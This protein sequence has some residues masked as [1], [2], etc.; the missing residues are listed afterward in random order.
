[1]NRNNSS[2]LA[3]EHQKIRT[4][5]M[6]R[7]LKI[8]KKKR[9]LTKPITFEEIN[10]N[11]TSRPRKKIIVT[12]KRLINLPST[13]ITSNQL[14]SFSTAILPEK[15]VSS[16]LE[17]DNSDP[18]K[19]EHFNFAPEDE[20]IKVTRKQMLNI[21]STYV[22]PNQ[23]PSPIE[24]GISSIA[25]DENNDSKQEYFIFT[26]EGEDIIVTK[27]R[28]LNI[29]SPDVI[30]NKLMEISS[31]PSSL[32]EQY[33]STVEG[34]ENSDF[35]T[36]MFDLSSEDEEI[37]KD[38]Q[39]SQNE[40][41][42]EDDEVVT[43]TGQI[44]HVPDYEPFFP[45]LSETFEAPVIL[46][47]TTVL[48][49]LDFLTK[50]VTESRLRTY[51]F[52]ITRVS[53]TEKIVTSTTEVKPHIKTT[54]ITESL[55]KLTTLTLL[56]F[57]ASPL[58]NQM[59]ITSF[60]G[61]DEQPNDSEDG[62]ENRF[63]EARN[64]LATRVMSN[65][66]EVIVAGDK[67]TL[68]GEPDIKR[69]LPSTI[70]KP[71]TLKAS[72]LS[73]H[74]MMLMPSDVSKHTNVASSNYQNNRF[75]TKTCL[76]TF[77]YLTT[78]SLKGTK[79]VFSHEQVV[80]NIAT[81]ERNTGAISTTP[82]MGITLTQYA[83]LSVGEFYTT[84]TYLNSI[85][86]KD[87]TS[88][89]TSKH[90]VTNTVTAPDHYLFLIQPSKE[91]KPQKD[92]NTYYNTIVVT[93]TIEDGGNV[94]VV[95]TKEKLTQVVITESI[96]PKATSVMTSYIALD[97]KDPASEMSFTTTDVV[98]T[99]YV[100]YTYYN[101]LVENGKTVVHTN[102]SIA[103]DVTTEKLF[104]H[105]K[106]VSGSQHT[107]SNQIKE[108]LQ[109]EHVVI[110]ATKTYQTT[111]TYFTTLLQED[112]SDTPTVV[113]SHSKIV[114]NIATETIHP[115]Q[116]NEN[117]WKMLKN[118]LQT[119]QDKVKETVILNDGQKLEV[120][121]YK[122]T[123]TPT[124]VLP[125]EITK[126]PESPVTNNI[127]LE[128]SN[129]NVITGSTIIFFD[130]DP[131]SSTTPTPNLKIKSTNKN[132]ASINSEEIKKTQIITN[133]SKV[134]KS[135]TQH[136]KATKS[137]VGSRPSKYKADNI[138][139]KQVTKLPKPDAV[140]DGGGA[141]DLLG[142]GSINIE[143]LKALTPVINAMAGLIETNLKSSR[144]NITKETNLRV[145]TVKKNKISMYANDSQNRSPIY[146]PVGDM[147]VS[148]SQNIAS[149]QLQD[150]VDWKG[151]KVN[152]KRP[153]HETPLLNGG[154]PISPGEVITANSDVIV[155]KPGR[156]L[157]R[158][159][160]IP[161]NPNYITQAADLNPPP[162]KKEW[163][164][165][166]NSLKPIPLES[167]N[168]Y[169]TSIIHAV[170]KDEYIGPPPPLSSKSYLKSE[171]HKN[172]P[173]HQNE[174]YLKSEKL[175]KHVHNHIPIN[176]NYPR[177]QADYIFSLNNE[178]KAPPPQNLNSQMASKK[179]FEQFSKKNLPIHS[180]LYGSYGSPT[181][182]YA[183]NLQ[184]SI[185]SEPIVLPEIIERST[186]Q[187]LLVNIQPSQI[188]FVNIPHNRTTALI[189][190]GSTEPHRNGQYF[191][192]PS[193]YSDT[194][195]PAN[196][197]FNTIIHYS[198]DNNE[199]SNQKQV[200]SVIKVGSHPIST[201]PDSF[202]SRIEYIK[203]SK[204]Q[205]L[206]VN[207]NNQNVNV[208]VP[209]IS[210]GMFQSGNDFNAHVINHGNG[211]GSNQV[212]LPPI[213]YEV[214]KTHK[215]DMDK[216]HGDLYS[217]NEGYR[218]QVAAQ[219]GNDNMYFDSNH[220]EPLNHRVYQ[221]SLSI[222]P[223]IHN[224][225]Q[226]TPDE[227]NN[228][229]TA[230][231]HGSYENHHQLSKKPGNNKS[232]YNSL[233]SIRT[234]RPDSRI[235]GVTLA[236]Y[237]T[238]PTYK[239]KQNHKQSATKQTARPI[240][241]GIPFSPGY[242][243]HQGYT[244]IPNSHKYDLS[245]KMNSSNTKKQEPSFSSDLSDS[246][247][248][249]INEDGELI[250][251][252]NSR[253]LRPGEIPKEI[254]KLAT[255]KSSPKKDYAL[256]ATR[257]KFKLPFENEVH[258]FRAPVIADPRPFV[259]PEN[260]QTNQIIKFD[261]KSNGIIF[262]DSLLNQSSIR[263]LLKEEIV[264]KEHDVGQTNGHMPNRYKDSLT[265]A[266]HILQNND[267]PLKKRPI[268]NKFD[269]NRPTVTSLPIDSNI[270]QTEKNIVSHFKPIFTQSEGSLN[271]T[272]VDY[273]FKGKHIPKKDE[274]KR[275]EITSNIPYSVSKLNRGQIID[276]TNVTEASL[277]IMKP[278]KPT[279]II[280]KKPTF[281][282]KPTDSEET[283]RVPVFNMKPI[284][285]LGSIVPKP[286]E[287]IL[288]PPIIVPNEE[289]VG[290]SP[291][292]ITTYR[293]RF[294]SKP[295]VPSKKPSF[296]LQIDTPM[297]KPKPIEQ[298][299]A[300]T[301]T[302]S[303][304]IRTRRPTLSREIIKIPISSTRRP[305][306]RRP[307]RPG[308]N[309]Y[310]RSKSTT[311]SSTLFSYT[312]TTEVSSST[313][314]NMPRL[315]VI[316]GDPLGKKEV[317][318]DNA[319]EGSYSS[320]VIDESANKSFTRDKVS[321]KQNQNNFRF[322][323]SLL[324]LYSTEKNIIPTVVHHS[325]NE[326]KIID[327]TG[328]ENISTTKTPEL[329]TAKILPTRFVTHTHTST[330][331]I[332]KT[333]VIKTPGAP[334]ST[335][336]LLV[337]KT[338]KSTI[339]D[340]VTEFH[341]LV[342]PTNIVET[343]TTT[344]QKGSLYPSDVYGST[345]PSIQIKPTKTVI[346]R[347]EPS[348]A[349]YV[350]DNFDDF[351]ITDTDPP[352]ISNE[353]H[354]SMEDNN[355]ILVVMTDKNRGSII[356]IPPVEEVHNRDEML[357]NKVNDILI[358]GVLS[359]DPPSIDIDP[360]IITDRCHPECKASRNEL[361][362][363]T[364]GM[365]SCVCRPGFARM[366]SDRPCNP[367]YT[368]TLEIELDR[369]AR[370]K[371][372]Y[373]ENL[374]NTNTSEYARLASSTH[375]AL[376]RMVMQS[377]L[378]DIYHGV[379]VHSFKPGKS[380]VLNS[381]YL[382][383]SDNTDEKR[384]EDVLKK[385]LRGNN[386]SL[387]GT[388]LHAS[389]E[390]QQS[391]K[392]KDFDECRN[393][394]FHDCS[395]NAQCFNLKGTYTCSCKEGFSDMS[396]NILYPG[397]KCSAELIGCEKCNY[398]GTCYSRGEDQVICECFQWYSGETCFV[399]LKV[400]LIGLVCLGFILFVLLLVCCVVTCC[401]KKSTPKI[402][403]GL[404][405]FPQ[406][407]PHPTDRS[408]LDRRAMIPDTSSEDS[409]SETNSLPYV[410]KQ[411]PKRPKSALKKSSIPKKHGADSNPNIQSLNEQKDRSLTVMIPRAKYHPAPTAPNMSSYTTFDA[412]KATISKPQSN[413][414]KLLSYLDAGP[415]PHKTDNKR[416]Y[417]S[418][419]SESYLNEDEPISR[420]TS[421]ALVSAGFEVSATVANNMGT[422]GTTCGT[423]ADRS[424][425]A[426]L[427]QKISTDLLSCT[428]TRS[429]TNTLRNFEDDDL[430]PISNWMEIE[431]R[432]TTI[433]ESRSFDETTIPP[434]MKSLKHDY[435]TKLSVNSHSHSNQHDEVAERDLGSTFL[436]PHTHLY[437]ADRV[438]K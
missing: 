52:L 330:V 280:Y 67:S 135:K 353:S 270:V 326:I 301:S 335:L 176:H 236:D 379:H 23:L 81:E 308:Y 82:S 50:T 97:V 287:D 32:T 117:Y 437:K 399:N 386:Y 156:I 354:I 92:T 262:R 42:Y 426:T 349:D 201:Q 53:G 170:N 5:N 407:V 318:L 391:L 159:P 142:L 112:N 245:V 93:K 33:T 402:N 249:L 7:K 119:A 430:D 54:T 31:T 223:D 63:D 383:L 239:P 234:P 286:A 35:E 400:L 178:I 91:G 45:E 428:G 198:S 224:N 57:D 436:L 425:N 169:S 243:L 128:S 305:Y 329:T 213:A 83:S 256:S 197:N 124:K 143:S 100:T 51:T 210:F 172:I 232:K 355:T 394:M 237:M 285:V 340:T 216:N 392:V 86:D 59:T 387:G 24:K 3:N 278:P 427:I 188:A 299:E 136:I 302:P 102:V 411:K 265:S 107:L 99:Y 75:V 6:R 186:G 291:P 226:N 235:Q 2:K 415:S 131:S 182:R 395:E 202:S 30:S 149:Y 220:K 268:S 281:S 409:R 109:P 332:T 408:T 16:I 292:P 253:P 420:K 311:S 300:T 320:T 70:F 313:T 293:P 434:P 26:P 211:A 314:K 221:S 369:L 78:Y 377:D 164:K 19:H 327:E 89:I 296:S 55:T 162:L 244:T 39:D 269:E 324:G 272:S 49:S 88:V 348:I 74:M 184:P 289:V 297:E 303:R 267:Q 18:S 44:Q 8:K 106:K 129:P 277:E 240:Y 323:I 218:Q 279:A 298:I 241:Q 130:D 312:P 161:L 341:T 403:T 137:N 138:K 375:E 376:D 34:D 155:G 363:K 185:I 144:R 404:S 98:K 306:T 238:P 424:E 163:A 316:I 247:Y 191:D 187:P 423:E 146:I 338:E 166:P 315:E 230:P 214:I 364:N 180:D 141:G 28:L 412:S 37:S 310:N 397:R 228:S 116:L 96:P 219:M 333:T 255:L 319:V 204:P 233:N 40:Q 43:E 432:I 261:H 65:G 41:S 325:G 260:Y 127:D 11:A 381:F 123:I 76:T 114:Q 158:V 203:P 151:N 174:A 69:V 396:E 10:M 165:A 148:E 365:M 84:Y 229:L 398:H 21:P 133:T 125:I 183:I 258:Q 334:P 345:Y 121:A 79:T 73:E 222:R 358:A 433:S 339:V 389:M 205:D 422:L 405:F 231:R 217:F 282:L 12:R 22:T 304:K 195:Y 200:K 361:C 368:Y 251:E 101:T 47:K 215:H 331:T 120:T 438:S 17:N 80:S 274:P 410:T 271:K 118:E 382:Q 418:Q 372:T 413:E 193:P 90:T 356:K 157:P 227:N 351:I 68:P 225:N 360:R 263:D 259:R 248:D 378:R 134:K 194:E 103:E 393:V 357:N 347:V 132:T 20:D 48:T 145:P 9:K 122:K 189:Y 421:G 414:A 309:M 264:S 95:S 87:R 370:K 199:N 177:P 374:S 384:L 60:T 171:R 283:N 290:M 388:E 160:A 140:V 212:Q 1:M 196:E 46:L 179:K 242:Q 192:D 108:D 343:V 401:K 29:I 209:P 61:S 266:S 115:K 36:K 321:A 152:L 275:N 94:K 284:D 104:L 250:Q 406:R 373:N 85:I 14:S 344:V 77:T 350:D 153:T 56:D 435:D 4:R 371:L 431:P 385:Y 295:K 416:K 322:N 206:L 139:K 276:S 113:S 190:G 150:T 390:S 367:T 72:T 111:F 13:E 58:T 154:I 181:T 71:V 167:P 252:S 168:D 64:Y 15:D 336:T 38:K 208:K 294:S 173:L 254:L 419:L 126:M 273:V 105:P 366:F 342:K 175:N 257:N 207:A 147:E 352:N 362:Q 25:A 288:P 317:V 62:G 417:S 346:G 27:K 359:A 246:D 110:V 66:V 337:T 380:G 307:F 328:R 429:Q